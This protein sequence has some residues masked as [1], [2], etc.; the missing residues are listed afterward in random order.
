VE[1]NTEFTDRNFGGVSGGTKGTMAVNN[2]IHTNSY[3]QN[4]F[5]RNI[6]KLYR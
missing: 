6:I 2:L 1:N 5:E 3:E 4:V